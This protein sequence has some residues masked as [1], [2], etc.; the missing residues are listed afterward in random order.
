MIKKKI[1]GLIPSP[2]LNKIAVERKRFNSKIY[3]IVK[4]SQSEFEIAYTVKD[5]TWEDA[6]YSECYMHNKE[7]HLK[8][9]SP[10][11]YIYRLHEAIVFCNSD[12]VLTT[13]GAYWGRYNNE[14]FVTWA[15]PYD[16]RLV[17]FNRDAVRLCRTNKK[18]RIK[19]KVLPLVGNDCFH[20][21]HSIFEF[22][23]RLFTAGEAGLLDQPISILVIENIDHTILEIIKNYLLGFPKA[24]IV[25]VKSL[26][27]YECEELYFQ[28]VSGPGDSD[29]R[30]RLDYPWYIP[31]HVIEKTNKYF[32]DPV[33]EKIKNNNPKYEK[34][35]LDRNSKFA[36]NGRML[37]NRAE[38]HDY[39][40]NQ[41]FVDIEGSNLSLE[42]KA[43]IFYHAQEIIALHGSSLMNLAFCNN[44]RVMIF[45]NYRFATDP[46]FYPFFRERVSDCIYVTGQD[47]TDQFHSNYYIPLEKIKKAYNERIR[48]DKE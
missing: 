39:F 3:P 15:K 21:V 9:F 27:E 46:I 45:G 23:P 30:F 7:Q 48:T 1:K 2:L 33:T 29:S 44:A 18:E 5:A 35:Y 6:Y 47:D 17:S 22:L 16:A 34:I 8:V 28:N 38:V 26:I 14:E 11:E 43:D 41:G 31:R 36:K 19:G 13:Q 4:N 10:Q 40:Q 32:I 24:K 42:E 25:F 37:K 12:V 20:W